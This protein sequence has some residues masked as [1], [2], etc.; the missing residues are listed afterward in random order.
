MEARHAHKILVVDDSKT[1]IF[2]ESALLRRGHYQ[3]I[4]A[5]DGREA[6][7]RALADR[8]DLILMDVVMPRMTGIEACAELRRHEDTRAIPVILVTTKGEEADVEAGYRSGCT[9][10]VTKPVDGLEL[11][12]KVRSYL[13]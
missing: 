1:S 8:P 4:T 2:V 11:L 3:I 10:Y 7:D 9:D 13:A 12:A 6:V 5:N